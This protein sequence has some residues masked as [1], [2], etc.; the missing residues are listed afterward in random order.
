MRLEHGRVSLPVDYAKA[1]RILF[2][3]HGFIGWNG[4]IDLV[5]L[6]T[7]GLSMRPASEVE[8]H[9]A[10]PAP[11]LERR[12]LV[13]ALRR[14]RRIRAGVSTPAQD[15]GSMEA[16]H[17]TAQ[18]LVTGFSAIYCSDNAAGILDA[19]AKS[20][21]DIIFPTALPLG[22]SGPPRIGYIADFQHRRLPHLFA[23]RTIRN[24]DRSFSRIAQDSDAI[25][26]NSRAAAEDAIEFL[27]VQSDR[28]MVLPFTP[29]AQPWWFEPSIEETCG[30]YGVTPPYFLVCNHFWAH[31]DH[32]T[33]LRAFATLVAQLEDSSISLILTGDPIDHRDPGHYA[34]LL[35]LTRDL[36]IERQTHFLGLI[37][38]RDQLALMRGCC[39]LI[40]PTL[41][42]GGPGGGAVN[43]ALGL[44]VPA[45]V[46]DIPINRE[47]DFG[48]TSF[49]RAGD[50]NSLCQRMNEALGT[51]HIKAAPSELL[52]VSAQQLNVLG[53]C[54]TNYL[55][56]LIT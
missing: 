32:A 19:A 2:P 22:A 28:L 25:F 12:W 35:T 8:V 55:E 47:I 41:F 20:K 6:L 26:V 39:A 33:A 53:T 45:I 11:A 5:R 15:S 4:G 44:G 31:K 10:I 40:Q 38:K 43:L 16:L 50:P 30:R 29:Y 51:R 7:A 9:F 54:I 13:A 24:R 18:E 21:A 42:E 23:S 48:E 36:G 3:L 17:R 46:S 49:F 34:R 1:M 56:R 52:R 14:W 27:G 37:P